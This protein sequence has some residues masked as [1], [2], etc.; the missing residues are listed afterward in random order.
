MRR[1]QPVRR[2]WRR[3]LTNLL[4]N[5]RKF[6]TRARLEVEEQAYNVVFRIHDDGP[7]I[8][9]PMLERV[10]EPYYRIEPSRSRA[11][12]GMGLGLSIARDIAQ[13]HGGDLKLCNLAGGGLEAL[14]RIPRRG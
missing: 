14:V 10:F 7:G 6:A 12:G 8:S 1:S 5:C 2:P 13:A 4:D 3:L 11:T 9:E